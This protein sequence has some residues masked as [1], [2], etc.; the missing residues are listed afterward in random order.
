MS[1]AR[2]QV[3][4]V[5]R[6]DNS[7]VPLD[8]PRISGDRPV[9]GWGLAP[10]MASAIPVAALFM[11]LVRVPRGRRHSHLGID[12]VLLLKTSAPSASRISP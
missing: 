10:V 11:K 2:V 5:Q 6:L 4:L 7:P 9:E 12:L 3:F 8:D 1:Y